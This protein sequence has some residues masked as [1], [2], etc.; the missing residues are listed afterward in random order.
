[1]TVATIDTVVSDVMFV[2]ELDRLLPF[3]PLAGIPR[4]TIEFD[5]DP[6]EGD[7]NKDR[8]VDSNLR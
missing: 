6:K 1:V 5:G 3:H 8:A 4:R 2:T 7:N